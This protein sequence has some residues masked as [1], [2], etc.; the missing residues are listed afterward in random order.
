VPF[1]GLQT[2]TRA[3]DT[4]VHEHYDGPSIAQAKGLERMYFGKGIGRYR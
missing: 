3:I 2:D 1:I 4:I